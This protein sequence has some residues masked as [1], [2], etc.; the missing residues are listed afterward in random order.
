VL[1]LVGAACGGDDPADPGD[2]GEDVAATGGEF[3]ISICEPTDLIPQNTNETCGSQVLNGLFT[4]L[5]EFDPDTAE[6]SNAMAESIE[7]EDGQTWT[8][9]LKE[10]WT[11]HDGTPVTAE[12]FTKAWSY[13]A[14]GKAAQANSYFFENIVG[15]EELAGSKDVSE[16]LEG[17]TVV[18]DTTFEV[19]LL[20]PFSQFPLTVGYNAFY[21]LPDV[22]FDDPKAFRDAPVG[23]G[24]YEMD[25]KW[26]HDQFVKVTKYEDYAGDEPNADAIEFRIYSDV[27][28]AYTDLQAGNLDIV[29][30]IPTEVLSA[31]E[32]ELGDGFIEAPSS[33][34]GYLGFPT[35]QEPYDDPDVRKAISMAID[36]E[37]ITTAIFQGTYTPAASIISPV[38]AGYREDA[39]GEA[40]QFDPEAAAALYEEAGGPDEIVLWFNSDGGHE[41]WMEA[42]SNQ[43]R[44][45]LGVDKITFKSL[46]FEEYLGKLD[47]EA[48]TGPFRAAWVMDY[49]SPQNYLQPI[50]STSGSTNSFGYSNPEVDDLIDQGNAAESID[51]GIEFYHQAEDLILQDLPAAPLWFGVNYSGNG[52]GVENVIVDVFSFVRLGEVQVVGE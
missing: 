43:L 45:N 28:T 30:S 3:S 38:V 35:Y 13:G 41:E 21:P 34:F 12:S 19:E 46:L 10:G 23:N 52:P 49:P 32:S 33:Y 8:V 31:A 39:C 16:Q 6:P 27:N 15:A 25:G 14:N 7:S 29:D 1:S 47:E 40:C 51:E 2:D 11:F 36:R 44:Q 4:P 42:L 9:A 20:E 5:V 26:K 18:D 37:A 48:V 24:P 50:F 17:L 22:F